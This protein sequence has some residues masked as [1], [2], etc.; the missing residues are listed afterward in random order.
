MEKIIKI[1]EYFADIETTE[2]HNGYF[3][4][5]GEALTLVIWYNLRTADSR[6]QKQ[7]DS[8]DARAFRA[9]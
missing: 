2:E 4:S 1:T 6:W 9:S 5:V 7:R 8:R 3:C